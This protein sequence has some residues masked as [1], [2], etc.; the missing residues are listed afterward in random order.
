MKQQ[1]KYILRKELWLGELLKH[2]VNT[3]VGCSFLKRRCKNPIKKENNNNNM[4]LQ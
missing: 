4:T 2:K 3:D 1:Q